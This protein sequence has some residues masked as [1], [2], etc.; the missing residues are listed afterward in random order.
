M[1]TYLEIINS[2]DTYCSQNN[3]FIPFIICLGHELRKDAEA[4]YKTFNYEKLS[5]KF[6]IHFQFSNRLKGHI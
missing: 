1:D 6:L 2:K 5:C 3:I 4:N